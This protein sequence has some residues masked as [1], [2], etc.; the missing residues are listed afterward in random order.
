MS[1]RTEQAPIK[2]TRKIIS[3]PLLINKTQNIFEVDD[4]PEPRQ[5]PR[6]PYHIV[7]DREFKTKFRL[8]NTVDTDLNNMTIDSGTNPEKTT[9]SYFVR[10][11]RSLLSELKKPTNLFQV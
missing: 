7:G 11:R 8:N 1:R 10:T 6:T 5:M 4:S 9:T 3:D 2:L